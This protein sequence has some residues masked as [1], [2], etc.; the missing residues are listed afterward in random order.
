MFLRNAIRQRITIRM[1][2]Y[3]CSWWSNVVCSPVFK[4]V[5]PLK[6]AHA[7][8]HKKVATQE[9]RSSDVSTVSVDSGYWLKMCNHYTLSHL[10]SSTTEATCSNSPLARPIHK[11]IYACVISNRTTD[12]KTGVVARLFLLRRALLLAV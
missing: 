4:S 9:A 7:H 2:E 12:L 3:A 5:V 1:H 11:V 6:L 10:D 8:N